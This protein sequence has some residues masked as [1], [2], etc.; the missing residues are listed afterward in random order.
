[1]VWSTAVGYP[2]VT[3]TD[4]DAAGMNHNRRLAAAIGMEYSARNCDSDLQLNFV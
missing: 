1:M 4:S 3:E 2:E